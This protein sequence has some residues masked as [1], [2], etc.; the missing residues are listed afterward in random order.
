MAVKECQW[1]QRSMTSHVDKD[2]AIDCAFIYCLIE[3][4]EFDEYARSH[5]TNCCDLR[6]VDYWQGI[7][8]SFKDKGMKGNV[9]L[10]SEASV[11]TSDR[12]FAPSPTS[13]PHRHQWQPLSQDDRQ[14]CCASLKYART[15]S[16]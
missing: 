11:C 7:T 1:R 13:W 16:T 8:E 9:T 6:H 2:I 10:P 4:E 14:V 5:V 3:M 12:C 15:Q